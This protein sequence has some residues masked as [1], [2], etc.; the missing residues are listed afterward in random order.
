MQMQHA[1][2]LL[3]VLAVVLGSVRVLWFSRRGVARPHAW[4]IALLLLLQLVSAAAL[5]RTLF[6][7]AVS[8]GA[9]V[10]VVA[11]A[12]SPANISATLAVNE[13]LVALPEAGPIAA[14]EPVPDLA[15]ALR[16]APGTARLRIV[17]RGLTA[18]D[19]QALTGLPFSF[20]PAPLP[21]GL[22]ELPESLRVQA[23]AAFQ[24][25]GRANQVPGG[26]AELTDPSG[27]RVD[28]QPLAADGRFSLT[29]AARG[30]G[31][32]EFR[33]RILDARGEPVEQ[34]VQPVLVLSPPTTRVLVL[35]GAPDAEVKYLRRWAV[36]SGVRMT[37]QIQLG[38]GMR[39]GD[40]SIAFNATALKGFDAV[41]ID[42]RS[43]AD[44][45]EA[46]R[47]VLVDAVR[48]GL[49][50]LV[51]IT[52][53]LP[54][55]ARG[56]L[57]S[58]GL[59]LS[60]A[61]LPSAFVLPAQQADEFTAARL[62]PG[63]AD[64]PTASTA[65]DGELVQL[66]RQPLRIDT[67]DARA[68]LQDREGQALAA[69]QPLGRGRVAVWLPMDTFRLAL[70]GR[71]DLHAALWSD[72]ISTV[73]RPAATASL[74]AAAD[75]RQGTR[76]VLCGLAGAASVAVPGAALPVPLLLDPATGSARCAGF[77]PRQSGWHT[78]HSGDARVPFFVRGAAELPGVVAH[79][80]REATSRM[81]WS[82]PRRAGA[83]TG[84]PGSRWP[85]FLVWLLVSASLWWLERSRIGRFAAPSH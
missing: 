9:N 82:P 55:S 77:W 50:L 5:Y 59:R 58:F 74:P 53:P 57:A 2:V 66:T 25:R 21:R 42:E 75:G 85:W 33:V 13:R 14:A 31:R 51:R 19:H 22:V 44:L 62:G 40:P 81:A 80:E 6:P 39:L 36:D 10:L 43:W 47:R 83:T 63:S 34:A 68:W 67:A 72:A 1:I 65:T 28:R 76:M 29:G 60:T 45:G 48:N 16:R 38:A 37:T 20:T 27:Q 4:R 79:D 56:G 7:P 84:A 30:P 71:D 23:G 69:W 12:Q 26:S 41:V 18:R 8:V 54:A 70:M 15:T 78:L 73:A 49:G 46:R 32:V 61:A 17:G 35:A 52:G 11:T 64:A 24:I 3:L